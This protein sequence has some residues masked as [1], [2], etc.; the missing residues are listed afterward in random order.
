MGECIPFIMNMGSWWNHRHFWGP[1]VVVH[2]L[3]HFPHAQA[4]NA[5]SGPPP[6]PSSIWSCPHGQVWD[7]APS[8]HQGLFPLIGGLSHFAGLKSSP[9]CKTQLQGEVCPMWVYSQAGI[10]VLLTH[11][12]PWRSGSKVVLFAQQMLGLL[13]QSCNF[14]GP[15]GHRR[16][17]SQLSLSDPLLFFLLH[18]RV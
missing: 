14:L 7:E 1:T 2:P 13:C 5:L 4:S 12:I 10:G 17:S 3:S 16:H 11:P 6:L 18:L 15:M 8:S 9:F